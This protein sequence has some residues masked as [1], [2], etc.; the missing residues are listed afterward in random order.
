ME[1]CSRP[2]K[3]KFRKG[4]KAVNKRDGDLSFLGL[5]LAEMVYIYWPFKGA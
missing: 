1:S 5:K 3:E 4:R 2:S